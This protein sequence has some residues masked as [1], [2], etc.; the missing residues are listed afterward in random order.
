[1]KPVNDEILRA[2]QTAYAYP[3]GTHNNIRLKTLYPGL[4]IG[5]G[6]THALK[7]NKENF[8]FGFF[9]DHTTGM[10]VVPGSTVKGILSSMFGQ[11]K[12]EKYKEQKETLIKDFLNLG[13][14]DVHA[15]H[16]EI[17]KGI[18]KNSN[19]LAT[20][21][22]DIFYDA[23]IADAPNG[24]LKDDYIT[25]HE[26]PLKEPIPNR[27][28]KLAPNVTLE[29]CFD[30]HD[31]II[32]AEQKEELFLQILLWHG[33]GAKTNV[34]Y[35]QFRELSQDEVENLKAKKDIASETPTS[36]ILK[37]NKIVDIIGNYDTCFQ[38]RVKDFKDDF[39]EEILSLLNIELNGANKKQKAKIQKR[40]K[41]VM[42]W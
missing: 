32:T 14:L 31:G 19:I 30:L 37:E 35:G 27:M 2:N 6:Y 40:I 1:M 26:N 25:P 39:K 42:D 38:K 9:F 22:R 7:D 12:K 3:K 17:F 33:I 21:E 28:L 4:V 23:Y 11:G 34:G 20:Y 15:L 29:F 10:P 24:L 41:K 5:S 18:N 16:N 36:K 13:N 8:N